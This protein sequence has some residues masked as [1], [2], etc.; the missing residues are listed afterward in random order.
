MG[1]Y[2]TS[3]NSIP[4]V[5]RSSWRNS[6]QTSKD[7]VREDELDSKRP[8]T[9]NPQAITGKDVCHF[10]KQPGH[11]SKECPRKKKRINDWNVKLPRIFLQLKS[12]QNLITLRLG[13][14]IFRRL[15]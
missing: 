3:Y 2:K 10:C 9:S 14:D 8:S 15:K 11:F 4:Q 5:N 12:R 7:E 13:E 6:N 1:Q